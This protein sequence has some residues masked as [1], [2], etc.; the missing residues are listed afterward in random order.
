[1]YLFYLAPVRA[2]GGRGDEVARYTEVYNFPSFLRALPESP[3]PERK[4]H[5]TRT[6]LNN[7]CPDLYGRIKYILLLYFR[8]NN[9]D[10]IVFYP[11]LNS[12]FRKRHA[13][14]LNWN[15]IKQR[16]IFF[17]NISCK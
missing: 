5:R 3:A 9:Y 15:D 2:A 12:V 11:V 7:I 6:S 10:I 8:K 14:G 4:L 1:M 16:T 13:V 17:V